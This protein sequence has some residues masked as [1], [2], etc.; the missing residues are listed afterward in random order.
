LVDVGLEE[1][2]LHVRIR[3]VHYLLGHVKCEPNGTAKLVR[4]LK[5]RWVKQFFIRLEK[6]LIKLGYGPVVA[7]RI[8][9]GHFKHN[10]TERKAIVEHLRHNLK[11]GKVTSRQAWAES[12]YNI[13]AKTLPRTK[14]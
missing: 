13:S 2:L 6:H 14:Y 9:S 12:N 7:R 4:Y 11:K 3:D 1:L 10:H 8:N 5:P